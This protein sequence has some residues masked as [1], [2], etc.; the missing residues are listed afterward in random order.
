MTLPA[1][2]VGASPF[3]PPPGRVVRRDS[4]FF[5]P[6]NRAVAPLSRSSVLVASPSFLT[7]ASAMFFLF[8]PSPEWPFFFVI[9]E[10]SLLSSR[11]GLSRILVF[12]FNLQ[13]AALRIRSFSRCACSVPPAFVVPPS[14]PWSRNLR[15]PPCSPHYSTMIVP[16]C[17]YPGVQSARVLAAVNFLFGPLLR[18]LFSPPDSSLNSPPFLVCPLLDPSCR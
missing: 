14:T 4:I 8:R 2:N 15:F 9:A 18:D 13:K 3:L 16:Y 12:G 17:L 7:F 10:F 1:S 5:S 6:S 11:N